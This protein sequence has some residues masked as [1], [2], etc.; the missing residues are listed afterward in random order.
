M[1]QLTHG[2][3]SD[4][5][6]AIGDALVTLAG[7]TRTV[8]GDGTAQ[9]MLLAMHWTGD[10][11]DRFGQSWATARTRLAEAAELLDTYGGRARTQAAEQEAGSAGATGGGPPSSAGP[12]LPMTPPLA[13]ADL[14]DELEDMTPQERAD[15]LE[16]DEFRDLAVADP[17]GTKEAL[18]RAFDDGLFAD[19]PVAYADYLEQYWIDQ[20]LQQAG[21]D[22]AEWDP[23]QGFDGNRDIVSAVY[24]YYGELYLANPDLEW[25][26]MANMIGPSFAGGFADL[27][28][29]RDVAQG[30]LAGSP[31]LPPPHAG[32]L[33]V[34]ASLS[35]ADLAFY[36]ST[37]LSMQQEIFFDQG[38]MHQAYVDGGIA[39]IERMHAAGVIDDNAMQAWYGINSG[40]PTRVDD[41][42]HR[43]LWREQ[44]QIIVDDYQTM[45][46]HFPT[47]PAVTYGITL[48]G[49]PTIPGAQTFGEVFPVTFDVETP[50][51]HNIPFT[52]IDNPL[53][54]TVTV[55]TPLPEGNV[56]DQSS[57]WALIEQDTWPA[58]ADLTDEE[59]R[60][61]VESD[62]DTRL[63]EAR[64][65]NNVD[66]IVARI[67]SGFDA[68]V[69]Q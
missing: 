32:N 5:L 4:R 17:E 67:L 44:N 6:R 47:G 41:G 69:R 8:E 56:A 1:D 65:V 62:F 42:N 64:P 31:L 63:D 37:L 52:G 61:I 21:I 51:P 29:A 53:Q 54:G 16:S 66:R 10:D 3:D 39:E 2:A 48:I 19:D 34:L 40:D 60:A 15:Y 28:L 36:E 38:S 11:A 59:I 12:R 57:R 45:Y 46:N 43:L 30:V 23:S 50:G 24:E 26:A 68:D 20:A 14:Y 9:A 27:D 25:A 18:D 33:A 22:P 7:R 58:F 13:A 49:E 35:D 55:T